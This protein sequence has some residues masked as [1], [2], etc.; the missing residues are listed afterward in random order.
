VTA[1]PAPTGATADGRLGAV[2]PHARPPEAGWHWMEW[3][4]EMVGT[5]ILLLGGLSAVT[6]D[7]AARTPMATLV[8]SPSWRLLVTGI[9]FA[10]T[11]AL[12]TVSPVGRR[13]GAHLNPAVSLAFWL[14]GHLHRWDLVGYVVAQCAGAVAG[15]ALVRWWWGAAAASVGVGRT[16]PGGG[17]GSGGATGIEAGMTGVLVLVIFACVSSARTARWTPL[18]V[19]VTIAVLVWQVAPYTGTSLNPARSLGP[20]V[21]TGDWRAY[22][23]YVAGPLAGSVA[24][25]GLWLL[26]PRRTLTAKLFHDPSYRSIFRT[27]LPARREPSRRAGASRTQDVPAA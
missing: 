13:S 6:L 20:A 24:A 19:L 7:F 3:G 12:V 5:A 18:A 23:V 4:C 14:H 16:T 9:L 17:V 8:P 27:L 2:P 10:G 26:V 1:R 22:W 11:G 25:A 21:V 15:T